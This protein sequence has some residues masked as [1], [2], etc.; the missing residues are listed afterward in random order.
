MY[1]PKIVRSLIPQR[2]VQIVVK[3]ERHVLTTINE[4]IIIIIFILIIPAHFTPTFR[5]AASSL[6]RLF[7]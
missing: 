3:V 6:P 5:C 2:S 4:D 1:R 7:S